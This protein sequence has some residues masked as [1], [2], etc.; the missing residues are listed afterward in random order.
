MDLNIEHE[1]DGKRGAH[2][3]VD[4]S[5]DTAG[6]GGCGGGARVAEMTYVRAGA[7]RIIVDH[8]HVDDRLR[9]QGVGRRLLDA[10]ADL[11]RR[12]GLTI[13]ATCPYAKAQLERHRE[14][15]ADVV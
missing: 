8:T 13:V 6:G 10:T 2:F 9:G 5:G 14:A 11:A 1:D 15:Y 3:I 12:E 7:T 4:T